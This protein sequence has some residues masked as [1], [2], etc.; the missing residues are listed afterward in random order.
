MLR[1]RGN[2]LSM[3]YSYTEEKCGR[4]KLLLCTAAV[5][6]SVNAGSQIRWTGN[7]GDGQWT[8]AA[9][10]V[11]NQLPL[12]TDDV[13]LDNS[14]VTGNYTVS[15]PGSAAVVT[16]KSIVI[17]PGNS[18]NI[19]LTLPASNTAAPAFTITGPGYGMIIFSGGVM[20]NSSGSTA[21]AAIVVNDSVKI[22]NGGQ[23]T[24]N[25]RSAHAAFVTVLSKAPGT[26]TGIFKF[27]APGGGYTFSSTGRTYGTLIFSS[28]ASGGSQSYTTSAASPL[29]I[30]GDLII[31][32][33]SAVNLDIT[34]TT[35]VKGNYMQEGGVFN[36]A[37]QPNNNT[38][39]V[40]KDF[41]QT[42]GSITE[43]AA[44]LP[45]IEL[46][47]NSN[48][49][50]QLAGSINN[51]VNFTINNTA[52]VTLLNNLSLPYNLN[53]ING[54][55]N[56]NSFLITLLA[57]CN[58]QADSTTNNS[59]ISGPLRKEG[60]LAAKYFLFPVGKGNTQRWLE[61]KNVTGNYTV[62]FFKT[63]PATLAS[64]V[65]TG[66]HHISSIEYWSVNADATPAPMAAVEL[67][68]DN[69]NSGG[70]T[71]MT[72]LRVSQLLAGLWT[73]Q[74]NAA[75]TGTPGSAGS[76]VSNPLNVFGSAGQY[77][78]LASS[79]AFQNPLPFKLISFTGTINGDALILKWIINDS[80][81]PAGFELQSSSD[82]EH[83]ITLSKIDTVFAAPAYQY[84]DSRHLPGRQYYRLKM[85]ESDGSFFYSN[86]I[87]T[88]TNSLVSVQLQPSLVKN[89]ATLFINAS[90]NAPVTITIYNM[91][92]RLM[93]TKN[94]IL[95]A[96]SNRISF[97][98]QNYS[99]GMY[100][101]RISG[102]GNTANTCRFIKIE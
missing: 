40:K 18:K 16:I 83:F 13:L 22:Y 71:D 91:D 79:N 3:P 23:Y 7:A 61:L 9:N 33:G 99:A 36:L 42:G 65:G 77:F 27:D 75:T 44:G 90:S 45:G 64:M 11:D 81:Q 92:G 32:M 46:N 29:T 54:M 76:V 78:T 14:I 50:I 67:S 93:E 85:L 17:A 96:G 53:L 35:T 12:S 19:Q 89:T 69:V 28:D 41:I 94:A 102:Q 4:I 1:L 55:V 88:A 56:S 47:G 84:I 38:V 66:I 63:D 49:N 100:I 51:S 48:Q 37:S 5:F 68:F 98:L 86:V 72:A 74:G 26:E 62:E 20:L 70:V 73:D 57:G 101:V 31:K 25:T 58:L 15:L 2:L 43:T 8:T 30:N 52:G 39:Y 24:H 80:W 95:Y 59:F 82:N 34:A 21:G 87:V 10:W 60:L 97:Q 6:I